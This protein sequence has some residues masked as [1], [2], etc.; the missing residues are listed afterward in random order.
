M[1]ERHTPRWAVLLNKDVARRVEALQE[2]L[3]DDS[4]PR[5]SHARGALAALRRTDPLDPADPSVWSLTLADSPDD[6]VGETGPSTA[7]RVRH[8][9]LVLYSRHQQSQRIGMH[10]RKV[11]LGLAVG[12]VG[13]ARSQDGNEIDSAVRSRFDAVLRAPSLAGRVEHLKALVAMMRAAEPPVPLDYGL[14][15][16]GLYQLEFPD[17][18]T[19][20]LRWGRELYPP[21]SD[22][23]H[24]TD[25]EGASA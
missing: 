1:T 10:R 18:V 19:V 3:L 7:E 4:S 16:E 14:L 12:V 24:T 15:A 21:K 20:Q 5:Q 2:A 25:N 11:G 6:L 22:S 8:A 17:R 23:T 13:R 9:V